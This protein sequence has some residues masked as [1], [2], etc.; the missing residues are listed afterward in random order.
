M[1][2]FKV[3]RRKHRIWH[4]EDWLSLV[5]TSFPDAN[6]DE[7]LTVSIK[8]LNEAYPIRVDPNEYLKKL[9]QEW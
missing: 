2:R 8:K 7:R 1:N 9:I 4:F 3:A 6:G 5:D